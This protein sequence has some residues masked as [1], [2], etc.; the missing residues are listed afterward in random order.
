M[1]LLA[2]AGCGF[3]PLYQSGTAAFGYQNHV[4]FDVASDRDGY[5][6]REELQSRFG[7][8]T[9]ARYTLSVRLTVTDGLAAVAADT[10]IAR[11]NIEI[12][13]DYS[14]TDLSGAVVKDG[15]VSSFG[16]YSNSGTTVATRAAEADARARILGSIAD[17]IL[18]DINGATLRADQ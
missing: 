9:D 11:R 5:I 16:G 8:T 2:L 1:G 4:A 17:L 13:A 18:A 3:T 14:L 10:T 7:R 12:A 6:L 15:T